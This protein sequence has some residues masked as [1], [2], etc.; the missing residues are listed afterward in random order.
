[1]ETDG[2]NAGTE[3]VVQV[4]VGGRVLLWVRS[5][6]P[7][8]VTARG[9]PSPFTISTELWKTLCKTARQRSP[10]LTKNGANSS[11][12]TVGF[13]FFTSHPSSGKIPTTIPRTRASRGQNSSRMAGPSRLKPTRNLA[14]RLRVSAL[15]LRVSALYLEAIEPLPLRPVAVCKQRFSMKSELDMLVSRMV[16]GHIFYHEAVREFKKVFVV[17]VLREN[18]QNQSRTARILGMHRNTLARTL[19]ELGIKGERRPP[20]RAAA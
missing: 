2:G 3:L 10:N 11:L 13:S 18:G 6:R 16:D 1:M 9:L 19:V 17:T 5:I 14:I 12:H 20:Q 15:Y 4:G 8:R 7:H